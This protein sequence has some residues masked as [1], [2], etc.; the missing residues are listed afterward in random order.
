SLELIHDVTMHIV[1][2]SSGMMPGDNR[3][4]GMLSGR[5][6]DGRARTATAGRQGQPP[7]DIRCQGPFDFD[8]QSYVATFHDAVTVLR[9]NPAGTGQDDQLRNCDT[10]I[11]G[12]APRETAAAKS[13]GKKDQASADEKKPSRSSGMPPLETRWMKALGN[14]VIVDAPSNALVARG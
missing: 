12:F 9:P 10:L 8:M 5:V 4:S 2:G 14:P 13:A 3:P 6:T 1:P 11:V 7:L